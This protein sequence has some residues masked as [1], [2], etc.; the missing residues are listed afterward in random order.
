MSA[1]LIDPFFSVE[2]HIHTSNGFVEN[3]TPDIFPSSRVNNIL[4][5]SRDEQYFNVEE[6][7]R[8]TCE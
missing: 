8:L 2:D 1:N 6:A 5:E 7:E 3:V 4:D